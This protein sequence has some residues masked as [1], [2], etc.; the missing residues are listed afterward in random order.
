MLTPEI[1]VGQHVAIRP[2]RRAEYDQLVAQGA[3]KDEKIELLDGMLVPMSPQGVRHAW[4]IEI[5]NE[6]FVTA[7]GRRARVRVQM[8]LA[9]S[10][11][12]EPEPDLAIVPRERHEMDHP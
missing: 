12:A 10:E 11:L 5:L 7:L 1:V 3:F 6:L 2:L 8:P 9:L 4:V